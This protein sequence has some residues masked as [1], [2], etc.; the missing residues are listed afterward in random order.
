MQQKIENRVYKF[1]AWDKT[2]GQMYYAIEDGIQFE[3]GSS[4]E[5]RHFI[6]PR[7]DDYH[8]WEL[9][10]FTELLDKNEKEIYEGD[11]LKNTKFYNQL[12]EVYWKGNVV[13]EWELNK[14][15]IKWGGWNFKKINETDILTYAIY[16]NDIEV[17]GNIHENKNLLK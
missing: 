16:Q 1:R 3:D 5:F 9:M 12:I 8:Q 10:Q 6:T 11:I 4:Y 2:D 7:E 15:W 14:Y 17:I 13:G